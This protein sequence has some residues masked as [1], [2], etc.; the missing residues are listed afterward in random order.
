M[1][2][3]SNAD[4][5]V[6]YPFSSSAKQILEESQ[7]AIT[8]E[9]VE[10]ALERIKTALKDGKLPKT[11]VFHESDS[12]KEIA[13]YAAARMILG[14]MRNR[15]LTNKYAVAESKRTMAYLQDESENGIE[16][17]AGEFGIKTKNAGNS[18]LVPVY[19]YVKYCP[20][21][22]DYKLI[23]RE[24]KDG[25]VSVNIHERKRM[26][27]EAVRKHIEKIPLVKNPPKEI[28]AAS[29]KLKEFLPKIEVANVPFTMGSG[30]H[31]PCI[32]KLLESIKK[33]EN[34]GHQARWYL[35]V[36]LLKAGMPVETMVSLYSNLPDFNDKITRYQIEHA[37]N[38]EYAVPACASIV[39]YGLCCATCRIGSPLNWQRLSKEDKG[40][41]TKTGK[42]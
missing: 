6:K 30:D 19:T 38:K 20:K 3:N 37:K 36:Y 4:F 9:I 32:E 35:A 12:L 17:L 40:K 27:E 2:G 11:A 1:V 8:D 15:Y 29:E 33:H 5:A 28:K 31:P 23:N 25:Q 18:I 22:V 21:S 26:I 13:S 7:I 16:T 24:V 42:R 39:S 34:L 10:M 14:H 41:I